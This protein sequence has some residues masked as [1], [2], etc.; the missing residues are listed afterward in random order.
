MGT[1]QQ[2]VMGG[3]WRRRGLAENGCLGA[4]KEYLR[5]VSVCACVYVPGARNVVRGGCVGR[6]VRGIRMRWMAAGSP[7]VV[8]IL[9][10]L[11]AEPARRLR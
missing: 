3:C 9:S 4:R 11:H 5:C 10:S 2:I 1:T 8:G 6:G 7:L